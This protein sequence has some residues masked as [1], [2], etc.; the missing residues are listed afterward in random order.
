MQ[1]ERRRREEETSPK[2]IVVPREG[3]V[4]RMRA[5]WMV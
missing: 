5:A 1:R 2:R 3:P 4:A